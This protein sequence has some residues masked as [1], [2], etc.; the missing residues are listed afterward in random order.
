M[1]IYFSKI[2][3]EHL[4]NMFSRWGQTPLT[5]AILF[6]HTKVASLIRRH[7]R[8]LNVQSGKPG[9]KVRDF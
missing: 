1:C 4:G 5:E 3:F 7:E 6:K 9:G 8:A 2:N